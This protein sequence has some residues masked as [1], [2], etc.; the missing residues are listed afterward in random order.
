MCPLDILFK[1]LSIIT[2]HCRLEL[3][4][5][6][7]RDLPLLFHHIQL[8]SGEIQS[9]D[10][11]SSGCSTVCHVNMN[12]SGCQARQMTRSPQLASWVKFLQCVDNSKLKLKSCKVQFTRR[13]TSFQLHGLHENTKKVRTYSDDLWKAAPEVRCLCRETGSS[14]LCLGF[15]K[16]RWRKCWWCR[17]APRRRAAR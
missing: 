16:W 8:L 2:H 1:S 11:Y 10:F 13:R 4:P 7:H 17:N 14:W 5:I 3:W 9:R 6:G 15:Q 12:V